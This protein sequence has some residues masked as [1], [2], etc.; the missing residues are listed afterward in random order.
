[1]LGARYGTQSYID[2][3]LSAH[4]GEPFSQDRMSRT[5]ILAAPVLTI[6]VLSQPETLKELL[7]VNG[8]AK[9]GLLARF[10]IATPAS[11]LGHRKIDTEP[12]SM[13]TTAAYS[14]GLSTLVRTLWPRTERCEL[15]LTADAAARL[16][17]YRIDVEERYRP[18]RDLE[19]VSDFGGKI[20]GSAVRLAA[21]HHLGDF[22]TDGLDVPIGLAAVEWGVAVAEWS[23][24][25][26]TYA[27]EIVGQVTEH[28]H[29]ERILAWLQSRPG[30]DRA[31]QWRQRD[32]ATAL[33][34]TAEETTEALNVLREHGWVRPYVE[35][36]K[37]P[38]RVG[39]P[40][41]AW[42]LHPYLYGGELGGAL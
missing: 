36:E 25:H 13:F 40:S 1:M 20:A 4:V 41:P 33:K 7:A 14:E 22:G 31:V 6:A 5:A 27:L 3:L 26:Y 38:R 37:G 18:T 8:S 10:I 32:I 34:L 17:H 19:S 11:M 24:A 42:D 28:S 29:A 15:T 23:L 35:T 9:R 39:R 16:R 21:V 12:V 30:T 2:L